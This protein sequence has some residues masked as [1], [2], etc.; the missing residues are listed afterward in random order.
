MPD[1]RT[2]YTILLLVATGM[3]LAMLGYSFS[4]RRVRGSLRFAAVILSA[5]LYAGGYLLELWSRDLSSMLMWIKFEYLGIATISPIWLAFALSYAGIRIKPV[6]GYMLAVIPAITLVLVF[7]MPE[8]KLHFSAVWMRTDGPFP[9]FGYERGP[10]Y[11]IDKIFSICCFAGG[12]AV[13]L[14]YRMHARNRVGVQVSLAVAGSLVPILV[15]VLAIAGLFPWGIDPVPGALLFA[16]VLYAFAIFPVGFFD[17]VPQARARALE[18]LPDPILIAD[19]RARIVDA[20]AAAKSI[21][22]IRD[23]ALGVSASDLFAGYPELAALIGS[24]G[25][26]GEIDL[27]GRTT[28]RRFVVQVHPVTDRFAGHVGSTVIMRDVSEAR[29]ALQRMTDMAMTDELTGVFNRRR[30]QEVGKRELELARESGASIAVLMLDLDHFKSVNDRYG[31]AAGDMVL[32]IVCSR[33]LAESR[34][35]DYLFRYGGEEFAFILPETDEEGARAVAER[36]R[37]SLASEIMGWEN[38]P[39]RITASLGV[40]AAVPA[41][42]EGLDEY[43]QRADTALYEAKRAG[44]DCVR[45]WNRG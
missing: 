28:P 19:I 41:P 45:V 5:V 4:N 36:I 1:L 37:L 43:L 42:D 44:R 30:F 22:G 17:F 7:L 29:R 3:G 6:A 2:G 25:G 27:P 14:R 18:A 40:C 31:H 10:W 24:G 26:K 11:W 12:F 32:R 39:I 35:M 16:G 15:N 33:L 34:S 20:N 8:A 13:L 9:T 38:S 23:G 21:L